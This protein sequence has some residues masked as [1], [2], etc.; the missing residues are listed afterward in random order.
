M[1]PLNDLSGKFTKKLQLYSN[2]VSIPFPHLIQFLKN[3]FKNYSLILLP[4]IVFNLY[5]LPLISLILIFPYLKENK[6]CK[7][8]INHTSVH[9]FLID[10]SNLLIYS[11]CVLTPYSLI[12]FSLFALVS[13]I[14]HQPDPFR[15]ILKEKPPK[16]SLFL[17]S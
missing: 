10:R 9:K 3:H 6:Q 1:I 7:L 8:H 17:S 5:I 12:I 11:T 15:N 14:F 16:F 13:I 4:I 2:I